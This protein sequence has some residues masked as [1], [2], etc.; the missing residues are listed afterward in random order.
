MRPNSR[1]YISSKSQSTNTIRTNE[2]NA[3]LW[4][5]LAVHTPLEFANELRGWH[6]GEIDR[7]NMAILRRRRSY[8]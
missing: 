3:F 2:N 6:F 5:I 1:A 8:E 7:H 4:L